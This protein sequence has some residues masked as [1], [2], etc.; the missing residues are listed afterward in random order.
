MISDPKI[1]SLFDHDGFDVIEAYHRLTGKSVDTD[2]TAEKITLEEGAKICDGLEDS[3]RNEFP[4]G[5]RKA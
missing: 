4:D 2:S 1:K 5:D 3:F